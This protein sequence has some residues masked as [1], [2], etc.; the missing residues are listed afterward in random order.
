MADQLGGMS[1]QTLRLTAAETAPA[2]KPVV[3]RSVDVYHRREHEAAV[4]LATPSVARPF[5]RSTRHT[6]LDVFADEDG[7]AQA[8][9]HDAPVAGSRLQVGRDAVRGGEEHRHRLLRRRL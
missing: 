6:L 3:A 9:R 2:V 8:E 7:V 5:L 4:S 1:Q